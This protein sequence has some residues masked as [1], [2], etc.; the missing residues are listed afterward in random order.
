MGRTKQKCSG[1]CPASPM[2]YLSRWG[3][4]PR[5][6]AQGTLSRCPGPHGEVQLEADGASGAPALPLVREASLGVRAGLPAPSE[7]GECTWGLQALGT[8]CL[9][10]AGSPV[11][12]ACQRIGVS[13]PCLRAGWGSGPPGCRAPS[14]RPQQRA[15]TPPQGTLE[16][17]AGLGGPWPVGLA[18]LLW[19][20]PLRFGPPGRQSLFVVLL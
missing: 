11:P 12:L 9:G 1:G 2:G 6:G 3:W 19:G 5:R 13:R 20:L 16:A 4:G 10:A 8:G 15:C 14:G 17:Q 18:V 7:A